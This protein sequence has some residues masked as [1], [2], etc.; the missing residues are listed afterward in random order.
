MEEGEQTPK[1]EYS[2]EHFDNLNELSD[3]PIE[4]NEES[5]TKKIDI[6]WN[7]FKPLVNRIEE[8]PEH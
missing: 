1:E 3:C 6:L 8:I 7:K 4:K 5:I 2:E